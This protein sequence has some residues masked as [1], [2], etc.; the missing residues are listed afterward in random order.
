ME[1][2][3]MDH[4]ALVAICQEAL[5]TEYAYGKNDC[6]IVVLKVVDLLAGTEWVKQCKYKT[7]RGGFRQHKKLG[8]ES[9]FDLIK[10]NLEKVS[11]LID[12]DIFI[13]N[14]DI[15]SMG[16]VISGRLLGVNTEHTEFKLVPIREDGTYYRVRK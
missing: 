3:M 16:I 5:D 13:S 9:T 6:N 14:D 15:H 7:L 10:D 4:N 8:T 12:G 1:V 2:Q 11:V